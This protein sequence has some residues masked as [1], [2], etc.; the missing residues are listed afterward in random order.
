MGA[1]QQEKT[2]LL[3]NS[4]SFDERKKRIFERGIKDEPYIAFIES[5]KQD[6]EVLEN[7]RNAI[8]HSHSFTDK[9]R[10][11]YEKSRDEI[12]DKIEDF[13]STH[14][15]IFWNELGLIVWKKYTMIQDLPHFIEWKKYELKEI[16]WFSDGVFTW[17][18]WESHVFFD[19]EFDEF[20]SE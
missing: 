19:K 9:L 18:D 11:N 16:A 7:F 6:L 5:I 13:R 1:G 20:W 2:E 12:L 3:E 15:N 8:M 14:I 17:E 4:N 10:Q